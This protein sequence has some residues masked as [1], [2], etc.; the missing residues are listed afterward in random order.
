MVRR[1]ATPKG[2]GDPQRLEVAPWWKRLRGVHF[3]TRTASG[4]IGGS[5]II[6]TRRYYNAW[7]QPNG[8]VTLEP[9]GEAEHVYSD[10]CLT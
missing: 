7:V 4:S 10:I 6:E 1:K 2:G 3:M 9:M 5:G 8:S